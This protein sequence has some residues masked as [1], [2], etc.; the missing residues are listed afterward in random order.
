MRQNVDSKITKCQNSLIW[1]FGISEIPGISRLNALLESKVFNG[2]I[3]SG[4]NRERYS[5]AG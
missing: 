1:S 3:L 2:F 4:R 5:T